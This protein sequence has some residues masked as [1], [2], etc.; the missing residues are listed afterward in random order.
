MKKILLILL[1]AAL[2]FAEIQPYVSLQMGYGA[3]VQEDKF[4]NPQGRFGVRVITDYYIQPYVEHISSIPNAFDGYGFNMVGVN[5]VSP[6]YKD[7]DA[8]AGYGYKYDKINNTT[9]SKEFSEHFY[10]YAVR[11]KSGDKYLYVESIENRM[12]SFGIE[13]VF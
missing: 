4:H 7:F 1:L 13:W 5:V 3:K 9:Y 6:S 11:Y 10:R 8:Y 12:Y 2:A